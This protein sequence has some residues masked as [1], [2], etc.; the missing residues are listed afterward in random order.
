VPFV[1]RLRVYKKAAFFY[2]RPI[3]YRE[4]CTDFNLKTYIKQFWKN[5]IFINQQMTQILFLEKYNYVISQLPILLTRP[6]DNN[7]DN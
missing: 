2:T 6:I 4:S 3:K 1:V 7:N 5:S